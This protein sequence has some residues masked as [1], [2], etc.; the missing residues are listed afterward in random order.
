MVKSN[1]LNVLAV[2]R[3]LG[4]NIEF[5]KKACFCFKKFQNSLDLK[6]ENKIFLFS[7][8]QKPR[9]VWTKVY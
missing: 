6:G 8:F 1:F 5:W 7:R 2:N 4:L 9:F 3:L